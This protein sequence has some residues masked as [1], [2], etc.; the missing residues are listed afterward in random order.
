MIRRI[1]QMIRQIRQMTRQIRQTIRQIRQTIRQIRRMI[2]QIQ[3]IRQIQPILQIQPIRQIRPIRR[4]LLPML[5]NARMQGERGILRQK[6][7]IKPLVVMVN[8]LIP[9][10]TA[11]QAT[12]SITMSMPEYG[13][14]W[15]MQQSTATANRS[16]ASM[17]AT[18]ITV[19]KMICA[20]RFV[21]L[22]S[23]EPTL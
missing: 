10:G 16:P 8:P 22:N 15:L 5:K 9:R 23:T 13:N 4:L 2:R 7:A 17:S 21:R 19:R 1:R 20:N 6:S 18:Q 12:K 3:L 11:I 14:R